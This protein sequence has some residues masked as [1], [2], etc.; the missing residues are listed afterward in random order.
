M[1]R[2]CHSLEHTVHC[3]AMHREHG[4]RE[5]H[6]WLTNIKERK[7]LVESVFVE[8]WINYESFP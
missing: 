4:K 8:Q 6:A 2:Y 5:A 7:A 1:S 3:I